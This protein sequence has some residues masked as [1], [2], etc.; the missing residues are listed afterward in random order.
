MKTVEID[1][2]KLDLLYR[3][4]LQNQN[5]ILLLATSGAFAFVGTFI[6]SPSNIRLG[7]GLIL[8]IWF[9]CWVWYKK[10][11]SEMNLILEKLESLK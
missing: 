6:W 7:L 11:N 10:T 5:A 3:K 9:L 1:K 4:S 8:M 2:N